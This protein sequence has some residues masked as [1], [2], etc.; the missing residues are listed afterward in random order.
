MDEAQALL[1]V[2]EPQVEVIP[3][4]HAKF[5]CK[6]AILLAMPRLP[7]QIVRSGDGCGAEGLG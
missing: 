6:S 4:E 1:E 7:G 3:E 5:L 2:G